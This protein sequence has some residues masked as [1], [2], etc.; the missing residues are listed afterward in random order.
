[1]CL[2]PYLTRR[3]LG[4]SGENVLDSRHARRILTLVTA[5]PSNAGATRCSASEPFL[6]LAVSKDRFSDLNE[7]S[8][9]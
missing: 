1:M 3:G 2:C 9:L 4:L 6:T 7:K 8:F 5:L